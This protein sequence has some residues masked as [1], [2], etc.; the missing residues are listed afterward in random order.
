MI[1]HHGVSWCIMVRHESKAHSSD[2]GSRRHPVILW[3]CGRE[4][5]VLG[6]ISWED[7]VLLPE[8]GSH[9]HPRQ[10]GEPLQISGP[11]FEDMCNY[12]NV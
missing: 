7:I 2:S 1:Q 12:M 6:Q 9:R 11:R 3:K 8:L 4:A 10:Q 5:A